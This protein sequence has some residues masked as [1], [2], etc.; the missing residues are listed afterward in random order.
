[1][2]AEDGTVH[3]GPDARGAAA[4]DFSTN[5][6]GCGPC[7]VVQGAVQRADPTRYP[8]PAYTAL[9]AQLGSLHGVAPGRIVVAGS[10]SEFIVRMTAAVAVNGGAVEVPALAYGDYARAARAQGLAVHQGPQ[11]GAPPV[12][13]WACDPSSPLGQ[14]QAGLARRVAAWPPGVPLVLDCA[15]APLRLSGAS[16]LQPDALD[17]TWQLWSP[18]KAM[19]L[20]GVRG[21]YAIAPVHGAQGLAL[22]LRRLAPSW[23]LGAHAVAMLQAWA[24]AAAQA[25][26]SDSLARLRV[27]KARQTALC[28]SLGWQPLA[29]DTNYFC[30]RLPQGTDSAARLH[31]LRAQG[32]QLRDC[33]SFG[34]PGHVRLAVLPPASQDALARAWR[35]S[36]YDASSENSNN[37]E[38]P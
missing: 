12:L 36:A 17:R 29:S 35:E 3:G 38:S 19:G 32:V 20:T 13:A 5:A 2:P 30:A 24:T 9:C 22:Q 6:N 23:P 7:P 16:S 26:L 21:A 8:D 37:E 25:W 15:Y 34:L 14:P 28:T 11:G 10:A 4:H 18:N 27:W 33:A 31:A 1:M